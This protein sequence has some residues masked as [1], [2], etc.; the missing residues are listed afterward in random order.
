[1][2][3]IFGDEKVAAISFLQR[4]LQNEIVIQ[5]NDSRSSVAKEACEVIKSMA[6]EFPREFSQIGNPK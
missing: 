1:M 6:L 2:S 3:L 4:L 5:L